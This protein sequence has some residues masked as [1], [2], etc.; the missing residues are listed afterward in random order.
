M[1]QFDGDLY[2]LLVRAIFLDSGAIGYL[3]I[4]SPLI[5]ISWLLPWYLRSSH[6]K[7]LKGMRGETKVKSALR[8][9]LDYRQY[10]M[11]HDLTLPTQGGS[12]QIDHIVVSRFGIFI[13]EIKT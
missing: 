2:I 4:A 8:R 10:H 9:G 7:N 13:I 11:F 6:F 1:L 3:L 5:I 12:T